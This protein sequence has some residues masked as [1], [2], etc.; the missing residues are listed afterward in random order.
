MVHMPVQYPAHRSALVTVDVDSLSLFCRND[1]DVDMFEMSRGPETELLHGFHPS[2]LF[3]MLT[4]T[5]LLTMSR[6]PRGLGVTLTVTLS[7]IHVANAAGQTMPERQHA[8]LLLEMFVCYG[9]PV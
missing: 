2:R 9:R 6:F 4:D 3:Q 5:W 8:V 7:D 1:F